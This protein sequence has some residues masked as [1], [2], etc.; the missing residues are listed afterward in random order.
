M[1][2]FVYLIKSKDGTYKIGKSKNP[3][4]RL[5]QLQ[6][7]NS[8]EL[9][10]IEVFKSTNFNK[11]EKI[12]HDRFKFCKLNGEWFNLN[13]IDEANFKEYCEV[14][15]KSIVQLKEMKNPFI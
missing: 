10:L 14:I 5:S 7:A 15:D 8:N 1:Y 9:E 2:G 12:L 13:I 4:K 3:K 11:I 6:T